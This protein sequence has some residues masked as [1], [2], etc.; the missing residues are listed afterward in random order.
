MRSA[1]VE[2]G[3]QRKLYHCRT[4]KI[5]GCHS[6]RVQ[7]KYQIPRANCYYYIPPSGHTKLIGKFQSLFRS[8]SKAESQKFGDLITLDFNYFKQGNSDFED[9]Y[10]RR[11]E[12]ND[13][14]AAADEELKDTFSSLLKRFYRLFESIYNYGR[15]LNSFLKDVEDG[16][17]IQMNSLEAIFI[18][19]DG[20]QLLV[21][22]ALYSIDAN[23]NIEQYNYVFQ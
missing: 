7:V 5:K 11:V 12:S 4:I 16:A 13:E 17:F 14:L 15:D 8:P 20:K 21:S 23:S 2:I 18:D 9:K 3:G 22:S 19:E 10:E 6:N 1:F